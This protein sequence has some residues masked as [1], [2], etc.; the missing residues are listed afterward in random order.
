[1][2]GVPCFPRPSLPNG[3][4]VEFEFGQNEQGLSQTKVSHQAKVEWRRKPGQH[5]MVMPDGRSTTA[6]RCS[7]KVRT[8][9]VCE[10]LTCLI[11][12]QLAPRGS[13]FALARLENVKNSY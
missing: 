11:Y 5:R 8:V 12:L 2:C 4:D 9:A 6:A 7:H 1:M 13:N 10:A 3:F